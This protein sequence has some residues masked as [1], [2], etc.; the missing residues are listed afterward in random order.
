MLGVLMLSITSWIFLPGG[1]GTIGASEGK[2]SWVEIVGK[3]RSIE[4]EE[5][6]E[7]GMEVEMGVESEEGA[8]EMKEGEERGLDEDFFSSDETVLRRL[9]RR[10]ESLEV[11]CCEGWTVLWLRSA[12]R[13]SSSLGGVGFGAGLGSGAGD[14]FGVGS[15]CGSGFGC[16]FG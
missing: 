1:R 15:C 12:L 11:D 3:W 7:A 5:G 14:G 8:V 4:E 16:G 6:E 9:E 2:G 10:S 13:E